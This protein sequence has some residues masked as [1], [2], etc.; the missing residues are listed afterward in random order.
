MAHL[1]Y[2]LVRRLILVFILLKIFFNFVFAFLLCFKTIHQGTSNSGGGVSIRATSV[3]ITMINCIIQSNTA[4]S[5]LFVPYW[6][7]RL[8]LEL[9]P[10]HYRRRHA[11]HSF[12]CMHFLPLRFLFQSSYGGGLY[13]SDSARVTIIDCTILSNTVV[14][15]PPET[16]FD[17]LIFQFRPKHLLNLLLRPYHALPLNDPPG[18]VWRWCIHQF[19]ERG[20]YRLHHSI[21]HW[22]K[23]LACDIWM[24]RLAFF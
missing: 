14:S 19:S 21:K 5:A 4:V 13:I 9:S 12:G 23:C 6:M 15:A 2:I 7:E 10:Q 20:I 17:F 22:S 24:G 16:L 11:D 1:W 8:P 3:S 18:K